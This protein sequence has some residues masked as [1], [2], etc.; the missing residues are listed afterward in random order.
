MVY[1]AQDKKLDRIVALKILLSEVASGIELERFQR[2]AKLSASLKHP[3]IVTVY[4]VGVEGNT[5]YFTMDYIE[6]VSLSTYVTETK[7]DF[8]KIMQ[9]MQEVTLAL[10]YAHSKNIIHRDIKPGNILV[11]TD[12]KPYLTDFGLA[13]NVKDDTRLTISGVA[14]GTPSYMPPEQAAGNF[15]M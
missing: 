2:E 6:G 8:K 9:I 10:S 15:R 4:E 13:R 11:D 3:G 14:M 7:P 12:G 1:A 5:H